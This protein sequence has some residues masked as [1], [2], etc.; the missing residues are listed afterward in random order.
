MKNGLFL[1]LKSRTCP[2]FP[3][4]IL[5][6][7]RDLGGVTNEP[8]YS[9]FTPAFAYPAVG[10]HYLS[11]KYFTFIHISQTL[12]SF[13]RLLTQQLRHLLLSH[14]IL[15]DFLQLHIYFIFLIIFFKLLIYFRLRFGYLSLHH[16]HFAVCFSVVTFIVESIAGVVISKSY[17]D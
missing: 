16:E 5:K 9:E 15:L 6:I 4:P 2:D 7:K 3:L 8:L 17:R 12:H 13:N 14:L 10:F 1:I 11:L